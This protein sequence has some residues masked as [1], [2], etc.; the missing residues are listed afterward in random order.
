MIEAGAHDITL[1]NVST[2]VQT[3]EGGSIELYLPLGSL[4][5][6]SALERAGIDVEFRDYQ[7]YSRD[8]PY[9][10]D[11][12]SFQSFLEGSSRIL[13]VSCMVSMLPFVLL[14]TKRFKES[15][16]D[17][18]IILGGPGPSG[19]AEA[20]MASMPW[21]DVV[22]RGE[23]EVTLVE[24]VRALKNGGS[25]A[26]IPGITYRDAGGVRHNPPRE[27]IRNLDG[28]PFP[29]YDRVDVGSYSNISIVT[30]RGCPY[31]CA[32]CDVGPLWENKTRFR[33][34]GNVVAE[35]ELLRNRYGQKR[36]NV[37][38]DTFDLK[39]DRAEAF[40]REV[41]GLGI[42]WTCL[43]RIDL[44]DDS[45]LD[46]MAKAGCDSVFLG[47][48][49]GSDAV[50][51]KIRKRFTIRE[52][53]EK[54]ELATKYMKRVVTSYIWGFPFETMDDFK[55]TILSVVSM[56]YLGAMAGLKLLSPMPLSRLGIECRDRLDFHEELCSVFATL[57][58]VAPGASSRKTA[59]PEEFRT[60]IRRYPDVFQ[61]FYYITHESV[62]EKA[63]YLARF[64]EKH[65]I[66]I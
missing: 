65:K 19:V 64:S 37:A 66:V 40:C 52:A 17:H 34:I 38:D 2:G 31:R 25:L 63:R 35:I 62:W 13:G 16:P 20:I 27:R 33:S 14:G 41:G 48:E 60:M 4:Y 46:L 5:L 32:F 18:T 56:W 55:S 61:G 42:G 45:L 10:L 23:G 11:V 22:G 1:V 3:G 9:R 43:A 29:A 57:G 47:I 26:S 12:E 28:I 24:V 50:L 51:K 44:M 15:H 53:T 30:G 7:L 36:V 54:A 6:V 49:S 21:V 58:N 8:L 59:L 39:R